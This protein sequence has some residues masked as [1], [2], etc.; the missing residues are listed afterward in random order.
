MNPKHTNL[1]IPRQASKQSIGSRQ[2]TVYA[3]APYNFVPLPEK[4]VTVSEPPN[5]DHYEGHTGF[6]ECELETKSPL[7]IRGMLS[8]T[9]FEAAGDKPFHELSDQQKQ[10]RAN[11]FMIRANEPVI[12]GSSLRGLIRSMVEVVGYGK[13]QPVSNDPLTYRAVGDTTSLGETY[14]SRLFH[15]DGKKHYTPRMQAGFLVRHQGGW[16]IRPATKTNQSTFARIPI[17]LIPPS[18]SLQP[19]FTSKNA[20]SIW[21][22]PGKYDY[23]PVRRRFLHF[24]F[25][26]IEEASPSPC[27][28]FQEAVLVYSGSMNKKK[29]EAVVF[30][31][32]PNAT[33]IQI[34]EELI[35]LYREQITPEQQKL[36]GESGV[37]VENQPV[38]YLIENGR[39]IFFGHT[40]MFRIPYPKTPLDF[41]PEPLR[42]EADLDLAEAIFGYTKSNAIPFGKARACA[43]RVF[44]SDA[45]L[46]SHQQDVWLTTKPEMIVPKILSSPKPTTFQHY[47]VQDDAAAHDKKNL[48]HYAS[49]TPAETVLRGHK[50]YWHKGAVKRQDIELEANKDRQKLIKQLTGIKPLR[51]GVKFRFRIFF[52]NLSDIE[53]GALLWVLDLPEGCCHSLGMGKPLGMGAVRITPKLWLG[54][55]HLRYSRLFEDNH[56]LEGLRSGMNLSQFKQ[57]F[58]NFLLENMDPSDRQGKSSLADVLRIKMLLKMLEFPGPDPQWTRYM[59]I[60]H[61]QSGGQKINEFKER[62]VLPDPLHIVPK[63]SNVA[64]PGLVSGFSQSGATRNQPPPKS[65]HPADNSQ[66]SQPAKGI[67]QYPSPPPS[68]SAKDF[69]Q[70]DVFNGTVYQILKDGSFIIKMPNLPIEK[71]YAKVAKVDAGGKNWI[72]GN[73][74]SCQVID[75]STDDLGRKVYRC[76][77]ATQKGKK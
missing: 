24:K 2:D 65:R 73:Q 28:C 66:P 61:T 8:Q 40:W 10:E 27:S 33:L 30:P 31:P 32:D 64:Q 29:Y 63:D 1:N 77:A 72:L 43:G 47:L 37:L 15:D 41:V 54:D 46:E 22:K 58:E 18:Q 48:K 76:R 56:W 74:A 7:Y 23:Q 16:A 9:T 38:F 34:D 35:R 53:L 49:A 70:G 39:L 67:K 4:V 45:T 59:E 69:N 13:V 60:E 57:A 52:E 42:R 11:F 75:I 5:H 62:P 17:D 6:I 20:F 71:G 25:L 55:R 50:F 19:W 26:P 51:A 36:L 68:S 12:P 21:V 44:I 14:R 3:R